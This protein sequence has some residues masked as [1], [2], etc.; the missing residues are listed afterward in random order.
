MGGILDQNRRKRKSKLSR[1]QQN[2][3][4]QGVVSTTCLATERSLTDRISNSSIRY[5]AQRDVYDSS[6]YLQQLL[7]AWTPSEI[8]HQGI[9][10]I[11]LKAAA[12]LAT[13]CDKLGRIKHMSTQDYHDSVKK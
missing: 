9:S 5:G 3:G 8:S 12:I 2:T 11:T 1:M 10:R 6:G 7:A 4:S 13:I